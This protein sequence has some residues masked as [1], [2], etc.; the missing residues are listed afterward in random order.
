MPAV[1][2]YGAVEIVVVVVVVGVNSD[3]RGVLTE[4]LQIFRVLAHQLRRT[5]AADVAV[6][7]VDG[8]GFRHHPV[9]VVGHHQHPAVKLIAQ[10]GDGLVELQLAVD[11]HALRRF[12]Q[13]QER[14]TAQK[15]RASNTRCS[16]PPEEVHAGGCWPNRQS[17]QAHHGLLD[18][19]A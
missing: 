7:A 15:A 6:E 9:Q 11:I 19:L 18:H 10:L 16:S 2:Y 3:G 4:Q 12:I 14:W 1:R 13:Y 8:V 5:L 17:V